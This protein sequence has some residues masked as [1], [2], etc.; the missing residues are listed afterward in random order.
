MSSS[1]EEIVINRSAKRSNRSVPKNSAKEET[2]AKIREA[3]AG[4]I[5]YKPNVSFI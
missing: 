1:D 5:K 4:G 3:R 2:L